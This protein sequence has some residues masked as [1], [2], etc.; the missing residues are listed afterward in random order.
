MPKF[1]FKKSVSRPFMNNIGKPLGTAIYNTA[2][3]MVNQGLAK[4]KQQGTEALKQLGSQALQTLET[5]PIP[6]FKNG[7]RVKRKRGKAKIA[8]VHAG[9]YILPVGVAPTKAQKSAV[10]K[11]HANARK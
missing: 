10:A 2:A 1:N 3:P 4:L 8:Q 6:V 7:G 5:T 9:E 11:R